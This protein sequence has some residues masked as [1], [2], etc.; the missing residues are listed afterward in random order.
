MAQQGERL[1]RRLSLQLAE[2]LLRLPPHS[3]ICCHDRLAG[4][5]DRLQ[6]S[7]HA[8]R[9]ECGDTN[10]CPPTHTTR[11]LSPPLPRAAPFFNF[12]P[13]HLMDAD[14]E[15]ARAGPR[16]RR[17]P[18]SVPESAGTGALPALG[19]SVTFEVVKGGAKTYL[20]GVR[21]AGPGCASCADECALVLA[22][23]PA[24]TLSALDGDHAE[25]RMA[26]GERIRV[27]QG[28]LQVCRSSLPLLSS[29]GLTDR[30]APAPWSRRA[31][32]PRCAWSVLQVRRVDRPPGGTLHEC[33]SGR[34]GDDGRPAGWRDVVRGCAEGRGQPDR[35]PRGRC[36]V[37]AGRATARVVPAR[38]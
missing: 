16:K 17:W 28:A 33:G 20:S 23:R 22:R 21:I 29:H 35:Q 37:F 5:R 34:G 6:P 10:K 18:D 25:V 27:H 8:R 13:P 11:D 36:V 12:S 7:L 26:T 3:S 32:L 38:A 9:V 14:M 4:S 24:Q 19:R 30:R 2:V 15:D 31:H 1:L